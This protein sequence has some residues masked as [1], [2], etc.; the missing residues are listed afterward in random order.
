MATPENA[1]SLVMVTGP[2]LLGQ[3]FNWGLLGVLIVQA[4]LYYIAFPRDHRGLKCVVAVAFLLEL[5]QTILLTYDSFR[6]FAKG[7]GDPV[8]LNSIGFFW[9][10]ISLLSGLIS[11]LAQLFYAWRIHV[12]SR[13]Y[14]AAGP[15]SLIAIVQGALEIYTSVLVLRTDRISDLPMMPAAKVF[16]IWLSLSSICDLMITCSMF[17]YLRR[18]K[19]AALL[20][21]TSSLLTRLIVLTVETGLI[22]CAAQIAALVCH[23]AADNTMLYAIPVAVT[24]KLYSNSMIMVI[25]NSR[26]RIYNSR[27]DGKR[28]PSDDVHFISVNSATLPQDGILVHMSHI[29][30]RP[31][32]ESIEMD[33]ATKATQTANRNEFKH[34][35]RHVTYAN[36]LTLV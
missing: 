30:D 20:K 33:N 3:L 19:N 14:W 31:E 13:S 32:I 4:Y 8:E 15:I 34:T 23:I 22:S 35:A 26:M 29:S 24:C 12:L 2:M 16:T 1:P 36:N 25:L 17:F 10:D 11:V 5:A 6:M 28:L 18:A 7:W 21:T 9:L 27:D